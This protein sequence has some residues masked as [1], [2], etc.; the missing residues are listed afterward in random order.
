[1]N[2]FILPATF[3][4]H[5]TEMSLYSV[6]SHPPW[7]LQKDRKAHSHCVHGASLLMVVRRVLLI[8]NQPPASP[9]H[10]T[11]NVMQHCWAAL[12]AI[13]HIYTLGKEYREQQLSFL[14]AES[15]CSSA[16]WRTKLQHTQAEVY[17]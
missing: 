14:S 13:T 4:D 15:G 9:T 1:M 12:G 8:M 10:L 3:S 5:T 17:K 7:S 6:A 11:G 2:T 16:I